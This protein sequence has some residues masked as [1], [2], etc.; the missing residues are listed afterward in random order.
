MPIPQI[1]RAAS[2]DAEG[3]RLDKFI[4]KWLPGV[5]LSHL[6]KLFRTRRIRVN[7]AR[8]Y[9][10]T[11]LKSGD[12]VVVRGDEADLLK[13]PPDPKSVKGGRTLRP[14]AIADAPLKVLF[15]DNVLLAIDKP[16]GLAVHPGSGIECATL[17][18]LVR[19]YL[20]PRA[21][22]NDFTA[23]PAHRLDRDTSGV[24]LV[25][26]TRPCM[27]ALTEMFTHGH[28]AKSYLALAKGTCSKPRGVIDLPLAEHEQSGRSKALHGT[29]MQTAI[30]RYRTLAAGSIA[31]LLEC[32]IE[33]GRTHQIRRHLVAMGHPVAGDRRHGDFGFN[34]EL[35]SR[36]G[37]KRMFLHARRISLKHPLTG[38]P[39]TIAA[40]LPDELK[41]VLTAMGIA[42]DETSPGAS[43]PAS[44]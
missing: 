36:F 6:Y 40:P 8:G 13:P 4:R 20:G 31:S 26:K 24:I 18:D 44:S 33:T 10:E 22:R 11:L 29:N 25:A 19:G 1:E 15:E 42:F 21:T 17:V 30:T 43:R 38:E 9:P 7:A 2:E 16:S 12:L 41:A 23:S 39:L 27:V 14:S 28:P 37:L 32:Q 35:K 5:P 3:Q 34:R